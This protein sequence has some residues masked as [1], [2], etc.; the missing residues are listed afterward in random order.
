MKEEHK[1]QS[2]ITFNAEEEKLLKK[3]LEEYND[4]YPKILLLNPFEFF[5]NVIKGLE[6]TLK[7]KLNGF[8]QKT[9]SK[10][11]DY[12]IEK[13]YP[14]DYKFALFIKKNI[15]NR[16]KEEISLHYFKG[17][18]LSH[19]EDDKCNDYYVHNCGEKFQF[20]KYKIS[21]YNNN[22]FNFN[23]KYLLDNNSY[24]N[25]SQPQYDICL[26]CDKCEMIYRSNFIKFKCGL[27]GEEFYSKIINKN[28]NN[29][30][31]N[32]YPLATW[33]NYHC[34]AVIND[35]MKCQICH[36]KLYFISSTKILCKY[37]D[38]EINP[39]DIKYKCIL[40]KEN[41]SSEAKIFNP[42]EYKALKI[43]IKEAIISKIKAKPKK[44]GCGC[45]LNINKT[46]FFHRKHCKGELFLGELNNKKVVICSKCDSLGLY[47][48]YIWTCPICFKKFRDEE[49]DKESKDKEN[50]EI[51]VEEDKSP[52][53]KNKNNN[54][55]K[56]SDIQKTDIKSFLFKN[57]IKKESKYNCNKENVDI[58]TEQKA[59]M[60]REVSP[61]E[62]SAS[63]SIQSKLFTEIDNKNIIKIIERNE[64]ENENNNNNF[65]NKKKKKIPLI[66]SKLVNYTPSIRNKLESKFINKIP[67][68]NSSISKINKIDKQDK[69]K[70]ENIE[71]KNLDNLFR[72]SE[73][74]LEKKEKVSPPKKNRN[75]SDLAITR[76][77]TK[78]HKAIST[79]NVRNRVV[80]NVLYTDF[81]MEKINN[82]LI[83]IK[84]NLSKE[85]EKPS[86]SPEYS[87]DAKSN[88]RNDNSVSKYIE[89]PVR[90]LF[91]KIKYNSSVSRECGES[92]LI[93]I[94]KNIKQHQDIKK[95]RKKSANNSGMT[96][97]E[98]EHSQIKK[99][100]NKF[101]KKREI[102]SSYLEKKKEKEKEKEKE[103]EKEKEKVK[104]EMLIDF[105][106]TDFK[107]IKQ[108][109]QG[110]F[111]QI[112]MVEDKKN[113]KNKYAL[114]KIIASSEKEIKGLKQEYQ[115]LFDIQKNLNESKTK[116]SI[117]NIYGL[118]TKQLDPT[119]YVMYVLME[120]GNIDWEKEILERQKRQQYYS[121]KEL[122]DILYVLVISLE[123][124]QKENISH[125]DIKP[126]NILVFKNSN[127]SLCDK[128]YKLADFGEAKELLSGNKPTEKQTL[129][130]TELYMSPLLFYGLRSR[131]IKKYI[132]H[133]P[134]KSDV[135]SLGL[136]ILFAATLCFES[137]YDVRELQNNISIKII[138]EKYL[139]KRYSY[140][141]I[142]IISNMLDINETTRDDFVE[143]KKRIDNMQIF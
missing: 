135:F 34:N 13:V 87:R 80:S 28:N 37:C 133:N 99:K 116:I 109:G 68:G 20:F 55:N 141:I 140:K 17:E 79:G 21:N 30:S 5:Q 14:S 129:R 113:K 32:I 59:N 136:C 112:F 83:Q 76:N 115:I 40:C 85:N 124:L 74:N 31:T 6:F 51:I 73:K 110:S 15:R 23:S 64:N 119:T 70:D 90:R 88:S 60:K 128:C 122:M 57:I 120:L 42:L 36:S 117:V 95:S 53:Y 67:K 27:T 138:I 26:F 72:E 2:T 82:N 65:T 29:S 77:I 102:N 139:K 52:S 54:N 24:N 126:Q 125:R 134:Y 78:I 127:N 71:A 92:E 131:K 12:L 121:E 66:S 63:S 49:K 105:N 11:E 84:N 81:H 100:L 19:C 58:N 22:I 35:K 111:G 7:E 39:L 44:I 25:N 101:Y 104:L 89:G 106:V 91:T 48:I 16:T 142:S 118:S 114:K 97:I 108:I 123:K 10:I 62:S 18:I 61:K 4:T 8:S 9:K 75:I 3:Y 132:K 69:E 137:L 38:K 103:E 45:D 86:K 130:G 33:K 96:S 56:N 107:I 1:K 93:R 41:F 143:L 46:K 47:D 94:I 98:N 50:K 43:C